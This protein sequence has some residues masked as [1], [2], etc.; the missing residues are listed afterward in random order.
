[1]KLRM[2]ENSLFAILLRQRWWVSASIALAI[3]LV[4]AALLPA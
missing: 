2:A 3:G 1:M 4:A